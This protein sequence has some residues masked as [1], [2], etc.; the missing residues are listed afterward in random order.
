MATI[1]ITG[2]AGNLGK[3]VVNDLDAAG[4]SLHLAVM[5]AN[6]IAHDKWAKYPVDLANKQQTEQMV[7]D[8]LAKESGIDAGVFL[9]GGFMAGGIDKLSMEDINKMLMLNFT[10]AFHSSI[11]LINHF[12]SKVD[13]KLIYIG[14]KAAMDI[15]LAAQN[16]AYALSKQML[17]SFC[18]MINE[19]EN[20]NGITAHILLPGTLDTALNRSYMPDA[21]FSKWTKPSDVAQTILNIVEGRESNAVIRF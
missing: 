4:H 18:T 5:D 19:S 14:A 6:D 20:K 16:Q 10:T 21:D 13:G 7:S 17:Y 9:A 2:G 3:T 8:I 11:G 1:L 12:K 15:T